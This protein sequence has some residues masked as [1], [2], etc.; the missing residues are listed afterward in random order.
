MST[1]SMNDSSNHSQGRRSS[2]TMN[3]M[4]W[5]QARTVKKA[6]GQVDEFVTALTE[7]APFIERQTPNSTISV[8]Q[9]SEIQTGK[10]LGEGSFS[11]VYEI[12]VFQPHTSDA[13]SN[14][15]PHDAAQRTQLEQHLFEEQHK[16]ALKQP[17]RDM[18]R[19]KQDFSKAVSDLV[20]EAQYLSRFDHPNILALRGLPMGGTEAFES[21]RF[22]SYF[23][24]LDRL[25]DSLEQRIEKWKKQSPTP[26]PALIPRKTNYALQIANA[27]LYLHQRRII[28]RDLKPENIGFLGK[29][30]AQLF[31]F[32]LVRELPKGNAYDDEQYSMS[33]AGSQWYMAVE[34]FITGKYNLKADVYS[35]AITT[36]EMLTESKA[37]ANMHK[38]QHVAMVCVQGK[39]PKLSLHKFPPKLETVIRAAWGQ[40]VSA[41]PN[42]LEVVRALEKILPELGDEDACVWPTVEQDD[43]TYAM[44]KSRRKSL[45]AE[46]SDDEDDDDESLDAFDTTL[47]AEIMKEMKGGSAARAPTYGDME[48]HENEYSLSSIMYADH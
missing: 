24:I 41:R 45:L 15:K 22:D 25:T 19:K 5:R 43:G 16:Y 48:M 44:P 32:G 20:V 14:I 30:Q 10:L 26:D 38:L 7:N 34:I 35:W 31:D 36:Y 23:L 6:A 42:M 4:V 17:K 39:R 3:P 11:Q 33:G 37:F 46:S 8:W 47:D 13:N 18:L 27:L 28:Y 12:T 21:G 1:R 2:F 29:H 40:S 9:R